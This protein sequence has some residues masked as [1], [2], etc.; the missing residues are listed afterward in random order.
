MVRLGQEFVNTYEHIAVPTKSGGGGRE[1]G[2]GA[3]CRAVWVVR[4]GGRREKWCRGGW[5][6][7]MIRWVRGLW[8]RRGLAHRRAAGG[9]GYCREVPGAGPGGVVG[10]RG[11]VGE[12]EVEDQPT[13]VAAEVGALDSVQ[14]VAAAAVG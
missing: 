2:T 4:G 3:G 7:E 8:G 14:E 6:A 11:V 5:R 9:A 10:A 12:V 13:V 1:G